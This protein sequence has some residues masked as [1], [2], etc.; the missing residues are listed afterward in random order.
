MAEKDEELHTTNQRISALQDELSEER[1]R[2]EQLLARL[3]K[4]MAMQL[5]QLYEQQTVSQ[6][7]LLERNQESNAK[8]KKLERKLCQA[9]EDCHAHDQ[10]HKLELE[11]LHSQHVKE[12]KNL[13]EKLDHQAIRFEGHQKQFDNLLF[14]Y[15]QLHASAAEAECHL[16]QVRQQMAEKEQEFGQVDGE[17]VQLRS[18]NE[19]HEKHIDSLVTERSSE[20]QLFEEQLES[21]DIAAI[22]IVA[23]LNELILLHFEAGFEQLESSRQLLDEELAEASRKAS[24]LASVKAELERQVH[25]LEEKLKTENDLCKMANQMKHLNCSLQNM[26]EVN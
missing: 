12:M 11:Q 4:T 6:T 19:A 24:D 22:E 17:I 26:E 14:R 13:Q 18:Q 15:D 21:Q 3:A 5:E 20:K 16:S 25:S 7:E 8:V 10:R 1:T 2:V 9:Q 23:R